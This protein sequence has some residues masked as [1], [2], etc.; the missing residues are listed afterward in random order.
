MSELQAP[1]AIKYLTT[2]LQYHRDQ[3]AAAQR[4]RAELIILADLENEHPNAFALE[5]RAQLV[6]V[7]SVIETN[8]LHLE[9][10]EKTLN[11]QYNVQTAGVEFRRYKN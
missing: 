8:T 4:H 6:Q 7:E 11:E 2:Q 10:I 1:E 3:L 9:G 5:R